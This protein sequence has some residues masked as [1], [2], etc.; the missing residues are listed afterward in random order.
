MHHAINRGVGALPHLAIL[1]MLLGGFTDQARAAEAFA[2]I[3]F[4]PAVGDEDPDLEG[5]IQIDLETGSA[6]T[7]IPLGTAGLDSPTDVAIHPQT[8]D[9]FVSTQTGRVLYFDSFGGAPLPSLV[10]GEP[11]GTFAVLPN[12]GF[13][14]GV[15][16]LHFDDDGTLVIG[17]SFGFIA[18][19]NGTTGASLPDL[20]FTTFPSGLDR[21]PNGDLI[22]AAAISPFGAPG[23]LLSIDS[24]G[25]TTVLVDSTD[26]PG[27]FDSANPTVV[28]APG[29]YDRSGLVDSADYDVW[30]A[31]FGT[32]DPAADGNFDTVVDAADYTVWRDNLGAEARILV[33]DLFTNRIMSSAR[34]FHLTQSS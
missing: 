31:A 24:V 30:E 33:A 32:F 29:D 8:N 5:I 12:A 17:T 7:F 10:P 21:A 27:I 16:T 18:S 13:G 22:V 4:P 34:L 9:L 14:D 19:Y 1:A 23:E 3:F 11:D 2:S 25:A 6:S 28:Y 20:G 26:N 15:N